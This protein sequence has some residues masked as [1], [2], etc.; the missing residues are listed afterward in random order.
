VVP[1]VPGRGV[2]S[3]RA[4]K[5]AVDEMYVQGTSTRKVTE[6]MEQLCGL[7]IGSAQVSRATAERPAKTVEK[8]RPTAPA[9]A[10][11]LFPHQASLLRLGSALAAGIR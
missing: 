6:V 11:A 4:L 5:L 10:A 8:Y 7:E 3:E 2:P 1:A 9:L